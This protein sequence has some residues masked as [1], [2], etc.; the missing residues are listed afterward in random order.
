MENNI[1]TVGYSVLSLEEFIAILKQHNVNAIA[2]VRSSPFSKFKPEFNSDILKIELKKN[3]IFYVFLGKEL[4]ARRE[5][6]DCY[7]DGQVNFNIVANLPKFKHGLERILEGAKKYRI[8]LMCAEKDPINCHRTI[9]I[10]RNLRK[11]GIVIEHIM[12]KGELENHL[13]TEKRLRN[14][15][16]VQPK[17]NGPSK[18][19][20]LTEEAYD[21]QGKKIAYMEMEYQ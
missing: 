13:E 18:T 9:L 14:L 20:E 3:N 10:C 4:G 8:A 5:E 17:F 2:D 15:L 1:F 19:E 16:N 11:H 21:I 6:K 7:E 12:E